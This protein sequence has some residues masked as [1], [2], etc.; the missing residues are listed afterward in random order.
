MS[1]TAIR[2]H[3]LEIDGRRV[4]VRLRRNNR[5]RRLILRA[6]AARNDGE[7]GVV[8]TLPTGVPIA[9]ALGWA[10]M[11]S[12]WISRHLEK[13]PER[14]PFTDGARVPLL[15]DEHIIRHAPEARRGVWAAGGTI[16]VSGRE[17]HLA[18]RLTDWLKKEARKRISALATAKAE[19]LG[20]KHGRISIRDT[21]SRW[22]SCASNGN[23][24]FSWRLVM[25]PEFV[26]D[27]VVAHEV[28]HLAEHNH[29]PAFWHHVA[30]LTDEPERARAWLRSFGPGLHRYG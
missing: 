15:G 14:I 6:D 28:A 21:K 26:F 22:G 8:V 16:Y 30:D 12:A 27:Y 18:R 4:P 24:N 23:L 5:A 20:H 17:E 13:L 3:Y 7:A 1:G 10:G 29:G 19:R 2:D 9:E 11:Q 25:A